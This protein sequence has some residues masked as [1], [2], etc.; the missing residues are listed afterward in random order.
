MA[1]HDILGISATADFSDAFA[2]IEKFCNVLASLGVI[3]SD[4]SKRLQQSFAEIGAASTNELGA[5]TKAALQE[6]GNALDET[7]KKVSEMPNEIQEADKKVEQSRK[8][9]ARL[10]DELSKLQEKQT[11]TPISSKQFQELGKQVEGVQSQLRSNR[12]ALTLAEADASKLRIQ[13]AKAQEAL[14]SLQKMQEYGAATGNV[15]VSV[16]EIAVA[17]GKSATEI[18]RMEKAFDEA[19][20][21][22]ANTAE[23][24]Q[25]VGE[26]ASSA[27]KEVD[28]LNVLF[29]KLEKAGAAMGVGFSVKELGSKILNVRGEFQ[30]LE[31]AFRTMIGNEKQAKDLFDQLVQT[32]AVTPFGLTDIANGAKQLLAF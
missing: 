19:S 21:K 8:A 18:N 12:S 13:Y 3:S 20:S 30:Q 15:N 11:K 9:I 5:K 28:G 27:Q 14:Q 1:E 16:S 23:S 6:L 2:N 31:V 24:T 26:A 22:A 29:D 25:K 32:A 10:E 17:A 7:K 4:T